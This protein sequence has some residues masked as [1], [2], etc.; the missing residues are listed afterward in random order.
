MFLKR[1]SLHKSSHIFKSKECS[2][3]TWWEI[4]LFK[5]LYVPVIC[6]EEFAHWETCSYIEAIHI[7]TIKSIWFSASIFTQPEWDCT[8]VSLCVRLVPPFAAKSFISGQFRVV[9]YTHRP[10][11]PLTHRHAVHVGKF[12]EQELQAT[13]QGVISGKKQTGPYSSVNSL[14][15]RE[16]ADV[17]AEILA[18]TTGK[19][20]LYC[21][22]GGH[23]LLWNSPD[24]WKGL[25]DLSTRN[26]FCAP[27]VWAVLAIE[28]STWW[29]RQGLRRVMNFFVGWS[30][31]LRREYETERRMIAFVTLFSRWRFWG[32][33]WNYTL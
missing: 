18:A 1:S 14:E 23:F 6:K 7:S 12:Q 16:C 8:R 9:V 3:S 31:R 27:D 21:G 13:L 10:W 33:R 15:A 4:A 2:C 25:I 17:H 5:F 20:A 11:H 19:V 24:Y 30:G 22:E 26:C 28:F 29:S 32:R